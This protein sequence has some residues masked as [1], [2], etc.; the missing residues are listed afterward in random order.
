M[1]QYMLAIGTIAPGHRQAMPCTSI[2]GTM[3]PWT[4]WGA[5]PSTGFKCLGDGVLN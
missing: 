3:V 4:R 1:V 2:A 5:M